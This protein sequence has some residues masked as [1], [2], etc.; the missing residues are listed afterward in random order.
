MNFIER[1][2]KKIAIALCFA[3][4]VPVVSAVYAFEAQP[5]WHG[6]GED[7]YYVLETTREQAKGWLH[8]DDGTYYFDENGD[9]VFG[10]QTIDSYTYYFDADGRMLNGEAE[11]DGVAYLFQEDGRLLSGWNGDFL[12]NENGYPMTN[13]F[14]ELEDGSVCYVDENGQKATGWQTIHGNRYYFYEDGTMARDMVR[15]GKEV[16]YLNEDGYIYEGWRHVNG[17]YYYFDEY[18]MMYTD[19]TA[20]IDGETY[21]FDSYGVASSESQRDTGSASS[22]SGQSGSS[23]SSSYT[24]HTFA[25]SG[26]VV[27]NAYAIMNSGTPYVYGGNT[28]SGVDCS[29]FVQ[30]AYRMAGINIPR[31]AAAQ[32]SAG[33]AVNPSNM[34]P[35]DIVIFNGGTHAAIYV[36]NNHI[37]HAMNPSDGLRVTTISSF[38]GTVTSVRRL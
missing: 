34:Q 18:G 25:A 12:Y 37:I 3:T 20:E 32:A 13:Q 36:G 38:Y 7:R 30:L 22:G 33:Y 24:D 9:L 6:E 26:D 4:C 15:L 1:N 29:G 10:W 14:M 31:T 19:T 23:G 35:G 5:G 2:G 28:M 21:V 27:A 11:I 8:L 17:N 16:Y